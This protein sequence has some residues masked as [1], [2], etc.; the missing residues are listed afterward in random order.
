MLQLQDHYRP[1]EVNNDDAANAR[2]VT[3]VAAVCKLRSNTVPKGKSN[4]AAMINE[5]IEVAFQLEHWRA[6]V[7]TCLAFSIIGPVQ[8]NF[9]I[10]SHYYHT[11]RD[12]WSAAVYNSY[13]A[14]QILVHARL[15]KAVVAHDFDQQPGDESNPTDD[16]PSGLSP[17]GY[18]DQI[19]FSQ[20]VIQEHI[21]EICASVP[22]HL[23]AHP[24]ASSADVSGTSS[25][26]TPPPSAA[27]NSLIWPLFVAGTVRFCPFETRTWIIGRLQYI[28]TVMAVRQATMMADVIARHQDMPELLDSDESD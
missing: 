11:Y 24:T 18:A 28:G 3:I 23:S 16:E 2:L 9:D 17:S 1:F 27:A 12:L 10:L 21:D 7:P 20:T 6:T 4:K 25:S 26:T 14:L 19:S 13:R 15:I 5:A 22:F 8:P